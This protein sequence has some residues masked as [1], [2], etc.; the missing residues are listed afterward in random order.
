MNIEVKRIN[1]G[2]KDHPSEFINTVN[3]DYLY[4]LR[5][6]ADEILAHKD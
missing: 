2:I 5:K 6:I 3:E 4:R 1:E